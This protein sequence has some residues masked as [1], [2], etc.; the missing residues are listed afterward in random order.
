MICLFFA[1]GLKIFLTQNIPKTTLGTH[2]LKNGQS[3]PWE[4]KI[5]PKSTKTQTELFARLV[6]KGVPAIVVRIMMTVYEDQY[7][8]VS[9]GSAKSDLF[10]I[11][12]GTRQGSVA[13]P[14]LWA[15]Y[16]DPLIQE[17]R[18]LGVGAHIAGVFMGVTMYADDLLLI[19]PTR[20]AMQQITVT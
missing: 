5:S 13:S 2:A 12:N 11:L 14:S 10:P 19:A 15:V 6:E 20:G 1:L 7:G 4:E 8:W 18:N 9:W 17:L 3:C 16:C